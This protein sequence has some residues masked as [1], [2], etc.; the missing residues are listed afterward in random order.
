MIWTYFDESSKHD[1]T[2]GHKTNIMV[3]GCAAEL[4]QWESL[5]E[6]WRKTLDNHGIGE[7][8]MADFAHSVGEFKE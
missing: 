6:K 8:H 2:T 4:H 3:A 5:S 1:P 7:F